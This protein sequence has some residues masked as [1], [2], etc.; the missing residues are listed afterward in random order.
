MYI[1]IDNFIN[2]AFID[3]TEPTISFEWQSRLP[4]YARTHTN[5]R[6]KNIFQ[7]IVFKENKKPEMKFFFLP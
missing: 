4:T 7:T 1:Y 6:E 3:Q 5:K 2:V